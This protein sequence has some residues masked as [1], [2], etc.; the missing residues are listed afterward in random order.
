MRGEFELYSQFR[1]GAMYRFVA[2]R[3]NRGDCD[4]NGILELNWI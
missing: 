2:D 3:R 4:L 1:A